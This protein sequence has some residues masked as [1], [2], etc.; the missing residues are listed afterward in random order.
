M[1]GREQPPSFGPPLGEPRRDGAEDGSA[2]DV[3]TR[4]TRARLREAVVRLASAGPVE[5][6]AVADLVRAARINRTTF[7]KHAASPAAVLEQVLY[8]DLDRVRAAWIADTLAAELPVR[9]V[10]DRASH[11]LVDHLERHD[12]LYTAGLVGHRSAVLH[13]LLV[14]HFT[15]SVR[16]LLARD[17]GIL[18]G[19]KGSVAWRTDAHSRFVAHGEVGVVEAWLTLPAPRDRS[20]FVSAVAA[21]LPSWLAPRP[22]AAAD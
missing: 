4:R 22:H 18:P 9:D 7:Y 14:D 16:D 13:Q 3:R 17:P 15:A 5:N 12:A 21:M 2:L 11:A 19:G 10:L 8:E 20:L 1:S 6:V